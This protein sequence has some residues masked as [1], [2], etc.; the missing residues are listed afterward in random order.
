MT[1]NLR[2]ALAPLA[3]QELRLVA[4][5]M[6]ESRQ[7]LHFLLCGYVLMPDHWHAL[8]W[9]AYPMTISR[10]VQ[11]IKWISARSLNEKRRIA[12]PVWQK[13]P[14]HKSGAVATI[15]AGLCATTRNSPPGLIIC[16]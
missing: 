16:T 8:I 14:R 9:T 15:A 6:D 3:D 2:R 1:V 4:A 10:V 12:G 13:G 7:R 11:R 5:A